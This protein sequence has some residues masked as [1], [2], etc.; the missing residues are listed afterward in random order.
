L[1]PQRDNRSEEQHSAVGRD[2]GKC[3]HPSMSIRAIRP[4]P[5][6]TARGQARCNRI[7]DIASAL[8]LKQGYAAT[9]L[10][11]IVTASGGSLSTLYQTFQDKDGL[12]IAIVQRKAASLFA[13]IESSRAFSLPLE[14]GLTLLAK[15]MMDFLHSPDVIAI[16]R[17]LIG[18]G[19]R[20]P[21]VRRVLF[22]KREVLYQKI[23]GYLSEC[24]SEEAVSFANPDCAARQLVALV[25]LDVIDSLSSGH[26]K[27][28]TPKRRREIC[29]SAVATFLRGA[30]SLRRSR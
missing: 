29:S 25:W 12:F 14:P 15:V 9:S 13:E 27:S 28:F 17:I 6:L 3:D 18:E 10:M 11:Q 1:V 2:R 23:S 30:A 20:F 8:F 7:L 16:H 19:W 5:Q 21:T 24:A 4:G 22:A 26:V